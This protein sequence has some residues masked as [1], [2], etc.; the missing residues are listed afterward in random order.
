MSFR[1]ALAATSASADVEPAPRLVGPGAGQRESTV[2][3]ESVQHAAGR[4]AGGGP[5]VLHL[6]QEQAGLLPMARIQPQ[7]YVAFLDVDRVR[8]L[9]GPDGDLARQVLEAAHRG[10]VARQDPLRRED[11][12]ER[13]DQLRL[14]RRPPGGGALQHQRVAVAVDDERGEAVRLAEAEPARVGPAD[15]ALAVRLRAPQPADEE[16]RV[17]GHV[18]VSQETECDLG[19]GAVERPSANRPA[20]RAPRP[21]PARRSVGLAQVPRYIQVAGLPA[22]RAGPV[23]GDACVVSCGVTIRPPVREWSRL[24]SS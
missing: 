17:D 24:G 9:A 2:V 6:V 14:Q 19:G 23:Q 18:G 22:P 20:R 11:L 8:D 16:R 7:P 13:L 12:L 15:R 3:A 5:V 4:I 1:S 21:R 10:I